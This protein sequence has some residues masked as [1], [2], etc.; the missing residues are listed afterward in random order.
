MKHH[1]ILAITA[2]AIIITVGA[3]ASYCAFTL[4]AWA[5]SVAY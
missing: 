5:L 3:L 4:V 1:H 2:L